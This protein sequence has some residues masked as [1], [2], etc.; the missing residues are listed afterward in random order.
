MH[1]FDNPYMF[2]T[3]LVIGVCLL[4]AAGV[5]FALRGLKAAKEQNNK[6][7][8]SISKIERYFNKL[9]SLSSRSVLYINLSADNLRV[10]SSETNLFLEIKDR[11]LDTFANDNASFIAPYDENNYIVVANF[12]VETFE[13]LAESCIN[14][15]NKLLLK[16]NSFNII[17]IIMGAFD[18]SRIQV[19]F[20]DAVNRAKQAC[21]LAKSKK[22]TFAEW[23]ASSGKALEKKIKIEKS[24]EK[25]IDDNHFFLEYQ[26]VLDAKTRKIVG[27]EVLSRLNSESDGVLS[28]KNFLFAVD[29]VGINNKFDY[30]IFEKNC[31]WIS[32]DKQ[33]REGYKYTINFS[34]STT[35]EP[36]FVEKI[37]GIAEKYN[38]KYS[39]LAV[40]ILEDKNITGE[41]KQQMI[42]NLSML[43]E[44]GISILLDDF[45]SGYT[46]FGDLQNFD[47]SIIKIDKS[48]THN[49]VTEKGFKILKNIIQTA[50]DI[51]FKTLCEGIE[52]K[53]QEEVVIEAGCDFL[54]GFYYYRPMPVS[55]LETLLDNSQEGE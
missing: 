11:L 20:D 40:E 50:K 18:S 35:S 1:I 33:Q 12:G 10:S 14:D 24:I 15:I 48:I 27:A 16:Q 6:A 47:I 42:S 46:T 55:K 32:N 54:Q 5:F 28:P 51:G 8:A 38:L 4:A 26:P 29:S 45:G 49:S 34:R 36:G 17:N 31:K 43:K 39:C 53:E 30:Y 25:E 2:I 19:S 44:K 7:F 21:M 9:G 52:T 22:I 37:T 13:E 23:N 41:A 3:V